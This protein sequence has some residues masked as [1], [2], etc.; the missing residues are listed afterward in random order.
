[1]ILVRSPQVVQEQ[2]VE[3]TGGRH[4]VMDLLLDGGQFVANDTKLSVS[5]L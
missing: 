5:C 1:M 4:P 3:I 2:L